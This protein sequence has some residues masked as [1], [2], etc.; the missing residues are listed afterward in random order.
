MT[1]VSR[2]DLTRMGPYEFQRLTQ[3]LL[4]AEFGAHIQIHGLGPDGGRDASTHD[5]LRVSGH[6]TPWTGFTVFQIKHKEELVRRTTDAQWLIKEIK[7]EIANW[8]KRPER[9]RQLVVITNVVLTPSTGGGEELLNGYLSSIAPELGLKDWDVWHAEKICRLLDTHTAVRQRYL[10]LVV[11]DL[12]VALNDILF[13]EQMDLADSISSHLARTFKAEK[14]AQLDQGGGV[15]DRKVPLARVFVDVPYRDTDQEQDFL[16]EEDSNGNNSAGEACTARVIVLADQ[17]A[18][19]M[20]RQSDT[21]RGRFIIIG[22]PGQGKSTL[23]RFLCQIYRAELLNRH[24]YL[25]LQPEIRSEV[26]YTRRLCKE[27]GIPLPTN[28]RF[29][30]FISLPKFANSFTAGFRPSLISFIAKRIDAGFTESGVRKWLRKYPWLLILDGL[31]EVPASANRES[32]LEAVSE[33]QDAADACGADLAVIATSRPQGYKGEFSTYYRMTLSELKQSQALRYSRRLTS[34]RHGEGS[35][36]SLEIMDRVENAANTDET[37]RLMT[38]PLQVTILVLL[39]SRSNRAPSQRY[40]LFS[41]YYDVI[42]ARELEKDTPSALILDRFRTYVDLLHWRIGLRLQHEAARASNTEAFLSREEVTL[43]LREMLAAEGY[44]EPER[45][46]NAKDIMDSA[47]DRLVFLVANTADHFG[48]ELRSL[49]EFCA[50]QG[51]LEGGDEEVYRRLAAISCSDHWRNV[52]QLA[53]GAIFSTNSARRDVI[54]S[55]CRELNSGD[56]ADFAGSEG[57]LMG[58]QLAIDILRDR[59]ADTAPR[60]QRLLAEIAVSMLPVPARGTWTLLPFVGFTDMAAQRKMEA[61]LTQGLESSDLFVRAGA[62]ANIAA[63]AEMGD[64]GSF[65]ELLS[66]LAAESDEAKLKIFEIGMRATPGRYAIGWAIFESL[67]EATPGKISSIFDR[68]PMIS[69]D[70]IEQGLG[71]EIK[72]PVRF[73]AKLSH[74]NRHLRLSFGSRRYLEVRIFRIR[75]HKAEHEEDLLRS[76]AQDAQL[77]G[78]LGSWEFLRRAVLFADRPEPDTW[79][80]AVNALLEADEDDVTAWWSRLPWPLAVWWETGKEPYSVTAEIIDEWKAAQQSWGANNFADEVVTVQ[81]QLTPLAGIPASVIRPP[82]SG[83]SIFRRDY[84]KKV[85]LDLADASRSRYWDSRV[86]WWWAV[87]GQ[88]KGGSDLIAELPVDVCVKLARSRALIPTHLIMELGARPDADALLRA[89]QIAKSARRLSMSPTRRD[90]PLMWRTYENW[91]AESARW[92][93]ARALVRWPHIRVPKSWQQVKSIVDNDAGVFA[94][95][96]AVWGGEWLEE[97]ES[98]I[99]DYLF[100]HAHGQEVTPITCFNRFISGR[101]GAKLAAICRRSNDRRY[102]A[103]VNML[104]NQHSSRIVSIPHPTFL[105]R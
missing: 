100:R 47:A 67:P 53:C 20:D 70:Y 76:A 46:Q 37:A 51:V 88:F 57:A 31:D 52:F 3:A 59:V 78:H 58:S 56:I 12:L 6:S 23:G 32:V 82:Q 64:S 29:P 93:L 28:L 36:K 10:G 75:G 72:S 38:T 96:I 30:I 21:A 90:E 95:L 42:Y 26:D 17:S 65:D 89:D 18:T 91:A 7:A 27:E 9:P 79:E 84:L 80:A 48:F 49:Q 60:H 15:D 85:A 33:F 73:A 103:V 24:Q 105:I 41:N 19:P 34:I 43:E 86:S 92:G 77:A 8:R 102:V 61:A 2:Y 69:W 5:S 54:V 71:R 22:G 1:T 4:L 14:Y 44:E 66:R 62:L 35:E 101:G 87:V 97:D 11:G 83:R 45:S 40:A 13:A 25:S 16:L 104:S 94:K 39:L 99:A 98:D 55:I 74:L 50:A 68:L 81:P 63:M